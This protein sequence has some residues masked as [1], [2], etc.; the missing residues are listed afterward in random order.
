MPHHQPRLIYLLVDGA[1]ARFVERSAETGDLVTVRKMSGEERLTELRT[2]QR[3]E[4]P[5]S[6]FES[7][8][9]GRHRVGKEE[10]YRRAKEVFVAEVGRAM[11]EM[12][13]AARIDG[14]VVVAPQ[15]LLRPLRESLPQNA[16][17]VAAIGKDLTK[18]PDNE[19]EAWLGPMALAQSR[20]A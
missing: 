7:A 16:Q 3:D 5:G 6:S 17:V 13:G 8:S 1:H 19:L 14:V 20:G 10:A 18:T 11:T 9:A 4:A 15:R 12:I 2:E